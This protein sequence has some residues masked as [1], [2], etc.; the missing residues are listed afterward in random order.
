MTYKEFT[1][2]LSS[3]E[4]FQ[5]DLLINALSEIGFNTFEDFDQSFKGYIPSS[6]FDQKKLDSL[7]DRFKEISLFTYVVNTIPHQN[8]N[9]LWESNFEP[10]QVSKRCYIRATFHEPHPEYEFEIVIDPKMAFGTGHHQ[11]TALMIEFMI[12][13]NLHGRKV[14]DM[15]CGTGIL[16][17]IASK[18]EA[19]EVI[20]I[21][22]DEICYEST[23]ENASLNG[24]RNIKSLCGSREVIPAQKFNIILANIN[25]NILL[26]QLEHYSKVSEAGGILFLS[27]FYEESDLAIIRQKAET[28]G[29]RY[30]QHKTL[31]DWVAVKFISCQ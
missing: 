26:N 17:I 19:K 8:W 15:G 1:F 22:Y 31:N 3:G 12:E 24:V 6:Y 9:E 21:D 13:E 7:A 16:G 30:L 2:T 14:L 10:L 20:A 27:G 25:R 18:M 11:T 23:K 4:D 5:K 28:S 29:F